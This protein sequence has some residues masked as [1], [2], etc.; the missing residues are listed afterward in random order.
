MSYPGFHKYVNRI[1]LG[2]ICVLAVGLPI[3]QLTT[4]QPSL[5]NIIIIIVCVIISY[6]V[7]W[8]IVRL[9]CYGT[10]NI[11]GISDLNPN[12]IYIQSP[13]SNSSTS[14]STNG[15]SSNNNVHPTFA[16]YRLGGLTEIFRRYGGNNGIPNVNDDEI[17]GEIEAALRPPPPAYSTALQGAGLP[18]PYA[19]SNNIE[20]NIHNSGIPQMSETPRRPVPSVPSS[21]SLRRP[22]PPIPQQQSSIQSTHSL[23]SIRSTHST[24]SMQSTQYEHYTSQDSPSDSH[25]RRFVPPIPTSSLD[26]ISQPSK[27]PV[28]P[29]PSSSVDNTSPSSSVVNTSPSSSVVN[30][31]Q[32]PKRPVPSI[33]S[34]SFDGTYQPTRRATPPVPTSSS[35][36]L[37]PRLYKSIS[38]EK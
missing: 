8:L 13:R 29:I 28:P 21:S 30:T 6:I 12:S 35:S 9:N 34:S 5:K 26:S 33:P 24:Q 19:S 3:L 14:S 17:N 25:T 22:V 7:Y 4:K 38:Y 1:Y 23:Q 20:I 16:S 15:G 31:S 27:R 2:L 11:T 10:P 18:P 37:P 36:S 32:S